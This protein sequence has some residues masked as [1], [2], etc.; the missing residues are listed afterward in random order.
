M[1]YFS[2][3]NNINIKLV[4]STLVEYKRFVKDGLWVNENIYCTTYDDFKDIKKI[5]VNLQQKD[6][7]FEIIDEKRFVKSTLFPKKV[8]VSF[9]NEFQTAQEHE[10]LLLKQNFVLSHFKQKNLEGYFQEDYTAF[11]SIK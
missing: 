1:I 3:T 10:S 8:G 7:K 4:D 5:F 11:E 9:V 2:V 6:F